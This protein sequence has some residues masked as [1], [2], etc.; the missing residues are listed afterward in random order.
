M[1]TIIIIII[2]IIIFYICYLLYKILYFTNN[3]T[4]ITKNSI[5][6]KPECISE[7]YMER[8]ISDDMA[9]KISDRIKNDK[10]YWNKKRIILH[11]L[12]TASYIEHNN[13]FD[14]YK[15]TYKLTNKIL[16]ENYNDLLNIILNYFQKRCPNSKV[17]YRFAY[18]GFHI[19][20]CNILFS[21]PV[22]SVHQDHQYMLLKFNKNEIIDLSKTLSFTLCLELPTN[23]GGLY[24]FDK[25]KIDYNDT[26]FG[27]PIK[28]EK[29][30]IDYY[31]GYI[32]CHN[33]LTT[34]MIAPSF[35]I[36]DNN[37]RITLQGHGVYEKNSNT[38]YLYW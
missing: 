16:K 17:K 5:I 34:H 30:K 6:K 36:C 37:Y 1:K 32:V 14:E 24:V 22:A 21:L 38:W 19:F 29:T 7:F 31:P 35:N 9:K 27:L 25:E 8:I 28:T 26:M 12:G 13:G 23:G 33:G 3:Y 20:T 10:Y 15:I 4:S 11:T 18:P 2:F